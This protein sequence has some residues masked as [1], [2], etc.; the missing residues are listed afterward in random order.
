[1]VKWAGEN[2]LGIGSGV[3]AY[4]GQQQTNAA[5]AR[6]AREQMDFQARM[7]GQQEAF[8]E[9]MSSTAVQRH[10]ADLKAAGLNP[11][12][13]FSSQGASSP[14]G[15]MAG[16]AMAHIEDGVSKGV[17]SA[18]AAKMANEQLKQIRTQVFKD[19]QTYNF[20]R[21]K[22]GP[23]IEQIKATTASAQQAARESEAREAR[24][25]QQTRN[26]ETERTL[27]AAQLPQAAAMAK[28]WANPVASSVLPWL[29]SA[30]QLG[31]LRRLLGR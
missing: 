17:S 20:M 2:L 9:R 26:L 16:G 23:E 7:A 21:D 3:A 10:V 14:G 24:E 6:Q 28:M 25:R 29:N 12:L 4:A 31:P 30:S 11:A 22:L 1:M 8:Q 27:T 19:T 15:A 13:A 18:I 5:N